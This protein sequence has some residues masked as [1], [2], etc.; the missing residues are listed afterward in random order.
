MLN[1]WR[2]VSGFAGL[3]VSMLPSGT[4]ERGFKPGRSCRIYSGQKVP[5]HAFLR[6]RSKAVCPMS[7]LC[8]M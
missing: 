8:G 3:A 7:L 6:K 5:Q 4:I 2:K 1:V